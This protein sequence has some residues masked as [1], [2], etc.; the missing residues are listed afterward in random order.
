MSLASGRLN[1]LGAIG[2]KNQLVSTLHH[3]VELF[4]PQWPWAFINSR[5]KAAP[6]LLLVFALDLHSVLDTLIPRLVPKK[7]SRPR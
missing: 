7:A 4:E 6:L 2:I 5:E 3:Q 1:Q